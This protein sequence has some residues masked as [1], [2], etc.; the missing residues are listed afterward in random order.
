MQIISRRPFLSAL[1][2]GALHALLFVLAFPPF[3]LWGC[4]LAALI[5][6][7]L[8]AW[9]TSSPW[10]SALGV[11]VA[12]LPMWGFLQFWM[13]KVSAAGMPAFAVYLAVFSGL[14]ILVA[15]RLHRRWPRIPAALLIA[16]SW[17]GLEF[18]RGEIAFD[19][20]AW[21]LLAHPLIDA[22]L[23]PKAAATLGAYG[24]GLLLAA[25]AG[26]VVTLLQ[27]RFLPAAIGIFSVSVALAACVFLAPRSPL[28]QPARIGVVQTNIP[29]DNKM[30][31]SI[32]QRAKDFAEFLSM[33]DEVAAQAPDI[34]VWPET[35]FPGSTL[36]PQAV[37]VERDSGLG[38]R[39]VDLP[40]TA[41]HDALVEKQA[42]K[43]IPMLVG[44]LGIEGFQIVTG[45]R[46]SRVE[47]SA[48]FNSAF[49]ITGGNVTDARY[50]KMFLTPFGEVMPYISLWPWLERQLLAVGASGMSF[51]LS[52]GRSPVVFDIPTDGRTIRVATP[53]CFEVTSSWVN[54]RL[55][56]GDGR[57]RADLLI[58]LTN[59]GWFN[60][61]DAGR[62]N[63]LLSARWRCVELATPM[64]RAAN[65]GIS[66]AIGAG[67][68]L[69]AQSSDGRH[70]PAAL[71][72]RAAG[73]LT[74]DVPLGT[75]SAT[76][77][78]VWGRWI[79]I[80]APWVVLG[81]LIASF[82]RP[83]PTVP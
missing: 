24:I 68:K 59:D 79:G 70:S 67:G 30:S 39:D 12:T 16:I 73:V 64:V 52:A 2:L 37:A 20:Y 21:Y 83:T 5:P 71:P 72:P 3:G 76:P 45:E 75:S 27:R 49:L 56:F 32:A 42:E 9:H 6:L 22:P 65:T 18:F 47:T 66:A 4:S 58:S 17:T 60:V 48:E 1:V 40:L 69:I 13:S 28:G 63:H 81:G 25:L 38:Y 29:Q 19:G 7:A 35:M 74:V 34:I 43:G 61:S 62:A 46:G 41:F 50:D 57:R 82:R 80:L 54:R 33:T 15:A 14:Y 31:W 53:I 8:L 55:V 51:N 23:V 77:F 36:S 26:S 11:A 44:S 78:V 10:R